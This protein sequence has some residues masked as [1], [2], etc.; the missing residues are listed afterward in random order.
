MSATLDVVIVTH[1]SCKVLSTCL[2]NLNNSHIHSIYIID[3]ASSDSINDLTIQSSVANKI[4][5][6]KNPNNLGFSK[7][8]SLGVKLSN[9]E[10][11][12]ILNPDCNVTETFIKNVI[13]CHNFGADVVCPKKLFNLDGN[14]MAGFIQNPSTVIMCIQVL[15]FKLSHQKKLPALLGKFFHFSSQLL[16]KGITSLEKNLTPEWYWPNGACFSIK[17]EMYLRTGGLPDEYFMY[18]E[19]VEFGYHLTKANCI[20]AMTNDSLYHENQGGS[21]ISSESRMR[22]ILESHQIYLSRDKKQ[23]KKIGGGIR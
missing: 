15:E 22:L 18:N 8:V 7:A 2:D 13:E 9:A 11:V 19:D 14:E 6:I 17:R 4:T 10:H 23:F 12:L 21:N 16:I 1:N 20:Y 5:L 3:N